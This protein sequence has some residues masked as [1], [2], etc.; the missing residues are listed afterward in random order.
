[1]LMDRGSPVPSEFDES[2]SMDMSSSLSESPDASR[3]STMELTHAWSAEAGA[4]TEADT[5]QSTE[6]MDDS[7]DKDTTHS[8]EATARDDDT[9]T[10][11]LTQAWPVRRV[12]A[13]ASE[14]SME[15][16]SAWSSADADDSGATRSSTMSL[17]RAWSDDSPSTMN[18]TRPWAP[19]D[20]NAS[21]L[22]DES[23]ESPST[24]QRSVSARNSPSYTMELTTAHGRI[25][26]TPPED[27]TAE[28]A[29]AWARFAVEATR[30]REAAAA[31]AA[32]STTAATTTASTPRHSPRRHSMHVSRSMLANIKEETNARPR[33]QSMTP[34]AVRVFSPLKSPGREH[35]KVALTQAAVRIASPERKVLPR[36]SIDAHSTPQRLPNPFVQEPIVSTPRAAVQRLPSAPMPRAPADESLYKTLTPTPGSAHASPSYSKARSP[37]ISPAQLHVT[38]DQF[39]EACGI[40]F[41]TSDAVRERIVPSE[42]APGA[43]LVQLA[44][45]A[46][47]AAPMLRTLRTACAELKKSLSDTEALLAFKGERFYATPPSFVREICTNTD[48][49]RQEA[50]QNQLLQQKQCAQL[51][52]KTAFAG[53][54]A[55]TQYGEDLRS[56]LSSH[57]RLLKNDEGTVAARRKPLDDVLLALSR[58]YTAL[59]HQVEEAGYRKRMIT[60]C[61]LDELKSVRDVIN[62][63]KQYLQDSEKERTHAYAK[64]AQVQAELHKI[65]SRCAEHQ[66]AIHLARMQSD[67]IRRCSPGEMARLERLVAH[68]E[69][70]FGWHVASRTSTLLQL[71]Y[72]RTLNVAIELDGRQ[73][74]VKRV[75]VSPTR[76]AETTPLQAAGIATVRA[77]LKSHTPSAV[78]D[79][80]R[81]I[82]RCW[83]TCRALS[84]TIARV[85]SHVPLE[86]DA[87]ERETVLALVATLV[88][89]HARAKLLVHM[90]ADVTDGSI[91]VVDAE[92]VYGDV[93]YVARANTAVTNTVPMHV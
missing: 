73:M 59:S 13:A 10:M 46:A 25:L 30:K 86:V 75:A 54:R 82:T 71:T 15:M 69:A 39:F 2:A 51:S 16:T 64:L 36:A 12:S 61:N 87:S 53:W 1:M 76:T 78:V 20:S 31:E 47:G 42:E 52:A 62:E 27:K 40:T 9:D 44:K 85:S 23:I 17:T 4:P 32:T 8:S 84:E 70:L 28:R 74:R 63:Q 14:S 7:I 19:D 3:G 49:H 48:A 41:P 79:V 18:M 35:A 60:S 34:R 65:S 45:M 56:Q 37:D 66:E 89:T 29:E 58:R 67:E 83:H 92:A 68:M 72:V 88:L 81:A 26:D 80:L 91:Y 50:L 33:S 55:D 5:T 21:V 90:E 38:I 77:H 22:S 43:T 11:Q 6:T 57:V 24:T 93:E